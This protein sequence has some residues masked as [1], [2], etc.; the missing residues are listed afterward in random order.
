MGATRRGGEALPEQK[1]G[2]WM[3]EAAGPWRA[4]SPGLRSQASFQFPAF[5]P[6]APLG[7]LPRV[8][9][10]F[11]GPG[12]AAKAASSPPTQAQNSLAG[13]DHVS[14]RLTQPSCW[15]ASSR[16]PTKAPPVP[17]QRTLKL[18]GSQPRSKP[19]TGYQCQ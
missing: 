10:S 4:S 17:E 7:L 8:L 14:P 3:L 12:C 2:S 6:Q 19:H 16:A 15:G 11:Q 9:T 5:Q 18:P 1:P 13:R